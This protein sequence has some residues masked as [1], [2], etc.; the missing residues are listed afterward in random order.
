MY[1]GH[2][3]R[4]ADLKPSLLRRPLL[5]LFDW[6]GRLRRRNRDILRQSRLHISTHIVV[7]RL[8]AVLELAAQLAVDL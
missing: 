6:L 1:D 8:R 2:L 4:L 7:R 5:L 3:W